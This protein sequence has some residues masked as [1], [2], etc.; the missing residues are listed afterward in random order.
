MANIQNERI[1]GHKKVGTEPHAIKDPN[2]G[3][4]IVANEDI[5]K[6]TLVFGI[7]HIT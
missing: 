5:K 2:T 1:S 6:A 4:L 3:D 7:V